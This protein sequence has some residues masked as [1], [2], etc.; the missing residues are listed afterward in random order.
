MTFA[1]GAECTRPR[2]GAREWCHPCIEWS[3]NNG[4]QTPNGRSPKRRNGELQAELRIAAA[5]TT[6]ECI[7]LT[8]RTGRRP[9]ADMNGKVIWAARAV[10]IVAHGDPGEA[11]VLHTCH[12][13]DDGCINLRHL[14]LG[15]QMQNTSDMVEAGRQSR[16]EGQPSALLNAAQIREMR[17]AYIPRVVTQQYLADRYG[18]SRSHVAN[19]V[20]GAQ[21]KHVD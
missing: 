21:W 1:D 18:V 16:G 6:N 4:G 11:H 13:G 17:A 15:D 3:R 14:Y 5:A 9:K 20:R 8:N 10:W 12:R 2:R 7:T 19:I